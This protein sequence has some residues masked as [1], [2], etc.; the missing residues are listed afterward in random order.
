MATDKPLLHA[1]PCQPCFK[2]PSSTGANWGPVCPTW[3]I[4][5]WSSSWTLFPAS[6]TFMSLMGLATA[7]KS[8]TALLQAFRG[9][10]QI[11]LPSPTGS[12]E[13]LRRGNHHAGSRQNDLGFDRELAGHGYPRP[14]ASPVPLPHSLAGRRQLCEPTGSAT[15]ILTPDPPGSLSQRKSP[16]WA[17]I[18]RGGGFNGLKGSHR[19]TKTAGPVG[20]LVSRFGKQC[21]K[22]SL[23]SS[24]HSDFNKT[25]LYIT[26]FRGFLKVSKFP[27]TGRFDGVASQR[28]ITTSFRGFGKLQKL[29]KLPLPSCR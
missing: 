11:E 28:H 5:Q 7:A 6:P 25:Q 23:L 1:N 14:Q 15:A 12:S 16:V 27:F 19:H 20:N 24:A 29:S 13:H 17:I 26:D 22:G 4:R 8:S 3:T 9:E 18:E 21:S 2:T 10:K